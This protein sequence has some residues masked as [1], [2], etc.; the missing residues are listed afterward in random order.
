MQYFAHTRIILREKRNQHMKRKAIVLGV[1][2]AS[3]ALGSFGVYHLINK[4]NNNTEVNAATISGGQLY[5]QIYDV[6]DLR[7][8]DTVIF[9]SDVGDRSL[10]FTHLAGNPIYSCGDE[11]SGANND[12]TKYYFSSSNAIPWVVENGVA[13]NTFSFRSIKDSNLEKNMSHPTS[14]R[15]LAYGHNYSGPGYSNI[16]ALGD[17]NTSSSKNEYSSWTVQFRSGDSYAHVQRYGEAY[18]TE[19][20][21][22]EYSSTRSHFGYYPYGS[23]FK[24]Y[25]KVDL[26]PSRYGVEITNEPT[27]TS[28]IFGENTSLDGLD[29]EFS[30]YDPRNT[31]L[32]YTPLVCTY[33][34]EP[35]YFTPLSVSLYYQE[36]YFSWCGFELSFK[37]TVEHDTSDE[38][39]YATSTSRFYDPRGTYVLGFD[40]QREYE[41]GSGQTTIRP[42]TCVVNIS[43]L[44]STP[45]QASYATTWEISDPLIDT[46]YDID[47]RSSKVEAITNNVINIVL[48]EIGEGDNAEK[49]TFIKLGNDYLINKG[50]GKFAKGSINYD[51]LTEV[52]TA[53]IDVDDENHIRFG[54]GN[55]ILAFDRTT[56]TIDVVDYYYDYAINEDNY[57]PI[58][59]YRLQMTAN[60]NLT[61][62][63]DE[64]KDRFFNLTSDYDPT[65]VTKNITLAKWNEIASLYNSLDLNH[66]GYLGSLTYTHNHETE[67]TFAQ[68]ADI[69]DSI[70]DIYRNNGFTDFMGRKRA[71]LLSEYP[72]SVRKNATNCAIDVYSRASYQYPVTATITPNDGF[73][74][75]DNV[76]VLMGG[77]PLREDGYSYNQETG[78]ITINQ[79]VVVDDITINVECDFANSEEITETLTI[80]ALTYDY[81]I[82][83]EDSYVF[84]NLA[85]RFGG[86]V[87][88][89]TWENLDAALDILGYGVLITT[90]DLNG[91]K[92][93]ETNALFNLYVDTKPHPNLATDT[94]KSANGVTDLT[95]DYYIWNLRVN[96]SEANYKTSITS[97]AYIKTANG[98]MFFN[99]VTTSVQQEA[100]KMI[101]SGYDTYEGSLS[102][103]ANL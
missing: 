94:T 98:T 57:I 26:N 5:A 36:A 103:L 54:Y 38:H 9:G 34:N 76:E 93:D 74:C 58:E 89:E 97:V 51:D 47:G 91:E 83:E 85:I 86:F 48:E 63:L 96:I 75:P 44:T 6:N 50:S 11:I 101:E 29:M 46:T 99:Q 71:M 14:G 62:S 40:Y 67:R 1:I 28:Y 31:T 10:I 56:E 66:K 15:Y 41:N 61:A 45:S 23:N 21:Y 49:Y 90:S 30:S 68:L 12:K 4:N 102:Y 78:V 80:A 60:L 92:L 35:D 13:D 17:L 87:S 18:S 2:A 7:I 64:F 27:K 3:L 8:G 20:Q 59:L 16:T 65:G 82:D 100:S 43:S 55:G 69:Y 52:S 32:G 42:C 37:A 88:K 53:A 70:Y 81:Q 72:R 77:Q 24:I 19:I 25:R 33:A 39:R 79:Y 73:V 84:T 95:K 22:Y